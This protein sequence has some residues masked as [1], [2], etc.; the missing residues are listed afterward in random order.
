[1]GKKDSGVSEIQKL[2]LGRKRKGGGEKDFYFINKKL[3][4]YL[5]E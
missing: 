1:M 2:K 4:L 3:T 5:S